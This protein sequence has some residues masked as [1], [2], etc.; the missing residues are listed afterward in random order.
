VNQ[1][2]LPKLLGGL[3]RRNAKIGPPSHFIAVPVQVIVVVTAERHG[4]FIADLA[5]QGI[6]LGEFQ[7][8]GIAGRSLADQAR[9]FR[10]ECQMGLVAPADWPS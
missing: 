9:L 3:D 2:G 4:E 5:P 7:M 6:G 8:M 10:N 1:A